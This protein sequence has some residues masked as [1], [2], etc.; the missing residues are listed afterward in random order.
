[1]TKRERI[2]MLKI[3]LDLIIVLLV[4]GFAGPELISSKSDLKVWLGIASVIASI[5]IAYNCYR[6]ID[7]MIED[8]V[9][10]NQKEEQDEKN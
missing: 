1:M 2:N 6:K 8:R 5:Y 9:F 10:N 4:W 3:V 7:R